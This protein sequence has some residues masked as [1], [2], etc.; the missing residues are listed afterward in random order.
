MDRHHCLTVFIVRETSST[1][2]HQHLSGIIVQASLDRL[3]WTGIVGQASSSDKHHPLTS[4]IAYQTSTI[5][6]SDR[7]HHRTGTTVIV[8]YHWTG[9]F[10]QASSSNIVI[11]FTGIVIRQA[12]LSN[13]CQCPTGII[14]QRHFFC[15][16]S[17]GTLMLRHV[18]EKLAP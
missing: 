4:T 7:C 3:H 18:P 14:A 16:S 12:S 11:Q 10:G 6:S 15:P 13:R 5:T 9:I 1:D 17:N 2:R 8:Y